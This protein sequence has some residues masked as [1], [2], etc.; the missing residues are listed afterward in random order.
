MSLKT[1]K[2]NLGSSCPVCEEVTFLP[3][4]VE[5]SEVLTC[6]DCRSQ[7]VVASI[8][9]LAVTLEEAPAMEEDWGE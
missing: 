1:T 4:G 7:L 8:D 3:E 5:E 6:H 9:N 2:E